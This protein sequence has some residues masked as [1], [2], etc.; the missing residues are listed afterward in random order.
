[1]EENNMAAP[2]YS[3]GYNPWSAANPTGSKVD[4]IRLLL[5]IT[6]DPWEL[7][8]EEIT[9]IINTQNTNNM[10][11]IAYKASE[12]ILGNYA[13][14][15]DRTMGPLSLSLSQKFDHWMNMAEFMRKAATTTSSATPMFA[16][17]PNEPKIFSI[18]MMDPK[19]QQYLNTTGDV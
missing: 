1:M 18:G 3:Y 15:V 4:T 12:S 10:K 11:W 5:R 9:Y 13:N 7:A 19:G 16:S 6:E 2:T 8:D 17:G 14:Q